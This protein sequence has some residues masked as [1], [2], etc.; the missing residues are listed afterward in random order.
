MSTLGRLH[1]K[2]LAIGSTH[3]HKGLPAF[4][5]WYA[6]HKVI[7][8]AAKSVMWLEGMQAL[9]IVQQL[10]RCTVLV[11]LNSKHC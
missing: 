10:A 6:F 4:K 8:H 7:E 11:G 9:G 1:K 2:F 3:A 5:K